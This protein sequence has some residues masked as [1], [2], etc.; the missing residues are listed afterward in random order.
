MAVTIR[1]PHLLRELTEGRDSVSVDAATAGQALEELEK[2][3]PGVKAKICR[4]DGSL[5]GF[6][7]LYV[8]DEDVRFLEGLST[9]LKE[10]DVLTILPMIAGG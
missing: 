4:E 7:N 1:I 9:E 3:F 10:G 2:K 8:N 5:H 6:V